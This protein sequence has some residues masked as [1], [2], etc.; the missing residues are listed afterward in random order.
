MRLSI[1]LPTHNRAETLE[2]ALRSLQAQ[3]E[4]DFEVL[5]CGDGCIDATNELARA[6]E[7]KD[8]RFRWFD[9]PKGPGFG[10]ANRNQ[11]LQHAGGE[12]IGF[13]AHD[14]LVFRDHFFRMLEPFSDSATQLVASRPLWVDDSGTILPAANNLEC[15][16]IFQDLIDGSHT[17]PATSYAHRRSAFAEVGF[18]DDQLPRAADLDFWRRIVLHH[19]PQSVRYLTTP[20]ALHFRALWKTAAHPDPH[21]LDGWRRLLSTPGAYPDLLRANLTEK[22]LPQAHIGRMLL[23]EDGHVWEQNVRHAAELALD[24]YAWEQHQLLKN[25]RTHIL[26]RNVEEAKL[27]AALEA[28]DKRAAAL[29]ARATAQQA[30]IT[31]LKAEAAAQK[32]RANKWKQKCETL[33]ACHAQPAARPWW[34]W[35][36]K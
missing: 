26:E 29:Q 20:S 33:R 15:S 36:R 18:W 3:T 6:W 10:Y 32:H 24:S 16:L 34:S 7:T 9:L 31:T 23:A 1:L 17:L 5:I 8:A 22:E 28:R 12:F 11:V 19:G 14:D 25:A 4:A 35:W 27:T 13:M 21:Q 30:Q 2:W